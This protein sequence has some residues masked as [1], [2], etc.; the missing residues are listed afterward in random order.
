MQ[1]L[2]H[3]QS[4]LGKGSP[5]GYGV[6]RYF[7]EFL[8]RCRHVTTAEYL[9]TTAFGN[10]IEDGAACRVLIILKNRQSC[11]VASP[12]A[13]V[14]LN[15]EDCLIFI[16]FG[17]ILTDSKVYGIYYHGVAW[18]WSVT[19]HFLFPA[20]RREPLDESGVLG[21]QR[22]CGKIHFGGTGKISNRPIA[23]P[24]FPTFPTPSRTIPG[25]LPP[26]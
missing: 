9:I 25:C 18:H 17:I 22:G 3:L 26:S 7:T 13:I 11:P 20:P 6:C 23:S 15:I 16:D 8:Q 24:A 10:A 5:H 14:T 21:E 1:P 12:V 19:F 4:S 2:F